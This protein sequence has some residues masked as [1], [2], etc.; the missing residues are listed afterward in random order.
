MREEGGLN[1]APF[2][3]AI[4]RWRAGPSAEGIAG[5]FHLH[6]PAGMF[7]TGTAEQRAVGEFDGFRSN[8]A[9]ETIGEAEGGRP[10][11]PLVRGCFDE[12]PPVE[13]ARADLV[14][15]EQ[16]TA[17]WLEEDGVPAGVTLWV[18]FGSAL[19]DAF[20]L[21]PFPVVEAGRIDVDV[22]AA[23]SRTAEPGGEQALARFDDSG[24]MAL[25]KVG[26]FVD[27]SSGHNGRR[28]RRG[29]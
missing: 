17:A 8:G 1:G 14:E 13:G 9:H 16:G 3:G 15:E 27:E 25:R 20:G 4:E 22:I 7:G 28:V 19:G 2:L 6:L 29:S 24:G 26:G 21:G 23:F 10:G 11:L 12:A 18:S 5:G